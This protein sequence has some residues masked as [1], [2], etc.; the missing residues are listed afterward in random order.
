MVFSSALFIAYFL[1][2]FFLLHEVIPKKGANPLILAASL[3]FYAWGAPAFFPVALL[4]LFINY[5]LVARRKIVLS[6]L[7]Q[8]SILVYYKY[9]NFIT[10][11]INWVFTGEYDLPNGWEPVALPIGISFLIFQSISFSLDI[12][13][14]TDDLPA[15]GDYFLFIFLFPQI[16]AGPIVRYKDVAAEI[17]SRTTNYDLKLIG[18]TRFVIGLAKKVLIANVIGEYVTVLY[19]LPPE[20]LGT[21]LLWIAAISYSFQIY[22]DFAGYSDM[23]I[24]LG[25]MMGFRFPENFNSPYVSSSI[26]EFWKR[27]HMTL[28]SWMKD[29][30]YIPLGGNRVDKK[31]RLYMN[32]SVVFLIS[33]LWHGHSWNFVIWGAFHGLMLII[34]RL[35]LG[36]VLQQLPKVIGILYTFFWVTLS[37]VCFLFTDIH[38]VGDYILRLFRYA[39]SSHD[40]QLLDGQFY[41]ILSVAIIFSFWVVFKPLL[42]IHDSIYMREKLT[43]KVMRIYPFVI[44]LLMVCF[45]FMVSSSF[46]PFIYFRF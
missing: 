12:Y 11:N 4:A 36:R 44:V 28:G 22:F 30:L 10:A 38:R 26:T 15:L 17:K 1:P 9:F 21:G 40:D 29:Y 33:G 46:N 6:I 37:W 34:E 27:W 32:L 41:F 18:F 43:K 39:P 8:V 3:F 5:Q 31:W 45:A 24:G 35:F 7:L 42:K 2:V 16:I 19:D 13:R 14:K 25:M 20:Q 23:A